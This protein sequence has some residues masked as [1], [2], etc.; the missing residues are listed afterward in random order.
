MD[1]GSIRPFLGADA[2]FRG[3]VQKKTAGSRLSSPS[4]IVLQIYN[5]VPKY[6]SPGCWRVRRP[7]TLNVR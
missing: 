3:V 6:V 4:S 5:I 2:A 7:E 1:H